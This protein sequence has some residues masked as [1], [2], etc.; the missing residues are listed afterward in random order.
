MEIFVAN[1]SDFDN[2]LHVCSSCLSDEENH[3]SKNIYNTKVKNRFIVSKAL[4]RN[5][6]SHKLRIPANKLEFMKNDYGKPFIKDCPYHFS[7]SHSE[8]LFAVAVCK[9][10]VGIDVEHM[11]ERDYI[12]LAKNNFDKKALDKI[13]ASSNQKEEFYRQWTL[14]EAAVKL[15]GKTIFSKIEEPEY[16]YSQSAG[17]YMLSVV[18]NFEFLPSLKISVI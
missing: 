4:T 1:I 16:S 3:Y 14:F 2:K 7:V 18:S 13:L 12:A 9:E 10:E 11:K 6:L 5:I 17:N 8:N 15:R